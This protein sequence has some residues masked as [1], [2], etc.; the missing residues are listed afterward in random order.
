MTNFGLIKDL[1]IL[2]LVS[3]P[4]NIFFHKIK[5]PSSI[6]FLIAGVI[7][8]PD[9]LHW[10]N[11]SH[12]IRNLAE[13][14]VVLLLFVIGLEFSLSRILKNL[15]EVIGGG[16]S[17]LILTTL[18]LFLILIGFGFQ[19]NQGFLLGLLGALSST[20]VVLKMITDNA[21]LDTLH[22]RLCI[23]ILLFQ[24]IC[25]VPVMLIV[26]LLAQTGETTSIS[27]AFALLK[28]VVALVA[29]FLSSRLLVP[30]TLSLIAKTGS[31][32]HLTLFVILIILGT[33]WVSQYLGLS[34]AMGAF[35]AGLII[36]DSE[37]NHQ[38]ILDILPLRDYF[39]S[40]F[41]ISIGMLLNVHYFL[42]N[43]LMCIGLALSV[44][45]AKTILA[46]LATW[47][48][49]NPARISMIVGIRLA[50]VGE[51][52]LMIADTALGM[53][54]L[55]KEMH[56][57]FL[58][59]SILSMLIAP[60]LIKYSTPLATK[61]FSAFKLS[62]SDPGELDIEKKEHLHKHVIIA[63]YGLGGKHLSRVLKEANIRFI[64][65]D[66]DGERVKQ[67]LAENI[68]ALYG[69][70]THRDTLRHA[71]IK[72]AKMIVFYITDYASTWQ[73]VKLA[74]ELNP[75][76]YIMVRT[77]Y[78]SHVEELKAAGANEVIP[79]EFETSIEIFSRVLKEHHIP[80]N[81]I[82][83]QIELIRLEGYA[84]FRGISL[85]ME[86]MKKFSTMLTASLTESFIILGDSWAESKHLREIDLNARTGVTL[87]AVVR[88]KKVHTH[89]QPEFQVREGDIM[90]LF[91]S[92]A[93]LDKSLQILQSGTHNHAG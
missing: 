26:P 17:Q 81:I 57:S 52:S 33:S 69:D 9:V 19:K 88:A 80:N 6:G 12:S 30:R 55:P 18:A 92:H 20:A 85:S 31:K 45:A 24:D 84:M 82:E 70:S 40:I 11:D 41:F 2:L 89:P 78:A 42:D 38:I 44:V 29:V 39:V 67:A 87:I 90:V 91:G 13:I 34:L 8:G 4:I 1:T 93:Q 65:M 48:A 62:A 46:F 49:R 28:S 14:G 75:N 53:G 3:L 79:E 61:L 21:E 73:G 56:Q 5:I 77:R 36:S 50:Q 10:I 63:G 64:V 74:R 15:K 66:L 25:V 59:V 37:Y 86:G 83:Q 60:L 7:I 16:I 76:V 58:I 27:I 35:I 47:L 72:T 51:F 54:L 32:E 22:G 71:G 23:G 43:A 68:K